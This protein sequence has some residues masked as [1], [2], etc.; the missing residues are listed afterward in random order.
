MRVAVLKIDGVESAEVSL[1]KPGADIR[2]REG[3]RLG[4]EQFR[5]LVK[6]SGFSL[7][8]VTVTAVGTPGER[9]GQPAI[10][11][12]G[13]NTILRVTSKS[14]PNSY[15]HLTDLLGAGK[16]VVVAT[17]MLESMIN[18]PVPTRAEVSDV[19][20]AIFEGADAVMLSRSGPTHA[21][22]NSVSVTPGG[23]TSAPAS[24][25]SPPKL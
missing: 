13:S 21:A 2:L 24:R 4:L 19:A 22:S 15:K 7:Q 3:N 5:R 12:T 14:E 23:K 10:D 1:Q 8:S 25:F 17:Q 6:N 11:V 20:T 16:P 18:A 9:D